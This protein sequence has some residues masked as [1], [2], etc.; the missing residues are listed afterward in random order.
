M[1]L[2]ALLSAAGKRTWPAALIASAAFCAL[3]PS[4]DAA[5]LT[6]GVRGGGGVL[7]GNVVR[8]PITSVGPIQLCNNNLTGLVAVHVDAL[9][10]C[11]AGAPG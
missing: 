8:L 11:S 3:A 2:G 4:A 9:G 7:A 5:V 1:S 10:S 6:L